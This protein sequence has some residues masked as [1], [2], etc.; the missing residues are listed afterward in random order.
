[1]I[2]VDLSSSEQQMKVNSETEIKKKKKI[3]IQSPVI[4]FLLSSEKSNW[5]QAMLI[6]YLEQVEAI[7]GSQSKYTLRLQID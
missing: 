3:Y 7:I 4:N 2:L 1:M 6:H 5:Q